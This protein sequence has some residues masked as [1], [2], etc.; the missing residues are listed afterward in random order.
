M[1]EIKIKDLSIEERV[2]L[3]EKELK[4]LLEKYNLVLIPSLQIGEPKP[5]IPLGT[6]LSGKMDLSEEPKSAEPKK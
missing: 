5:E 6:P 2:R 1:D 3:F 4:P